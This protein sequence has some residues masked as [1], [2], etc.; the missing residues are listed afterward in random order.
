MPPASRLGVGDECRGTSRWTRTPVA[1]HN[2]A[3][4]DTTG[5]PV[6][7]R[8]DFLSLVLP[9]LVAGRDLADAMIDKLG[10][11]DGRMVVVDARRTATGSP[12]FAS[13]LVHRLLDEGHA[14]QVVV[15]GAPGRLAEQITSSAKSLGVAARI[16]LASELPVGTVTVAR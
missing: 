14:E 12:S 8:E 16:D 1:E 11:V 4:V 3:M 6:L 15:V 10:L 9:H 5:A 13:Q 2:D 7:D